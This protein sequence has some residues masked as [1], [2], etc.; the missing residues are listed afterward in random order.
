MKFHISAKGPVACHATQRACPLGGDHFESMKDAHVYLA[1]K[2]I[3]EEARKFVRKVNV[4][5]ANSHQAAY[6][7]SVLTTD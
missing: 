1:R 2:E 4:A 5:E 3:L 7:R 6:V